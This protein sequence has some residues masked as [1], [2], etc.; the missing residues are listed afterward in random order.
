M[1]AILGDYAPVTS[2]GSISISL[3]VLAT[4]HVGAGTYGLCHLSTRTSRDGGLIHDS[5]NNRYDVASA[6][7]AARVNARGGRGLSA[8]RTALLTKPNPDAAAH[9]GAAQGAHVR[10]AAGPTSQNN[11][12]G[13]TFDKKKPSSGY[14]LAYQDAVGSCANKP[15]TRA[16][17]PSIRMGMPFNRTPRGG[18]IDHRPVRLATTRD[19]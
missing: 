15:S 4:L 9:T 19:T 1:P 3:L 18:R 8:A 2:P 12:S 13:H 5:G 7:A 17:T 10:G 11:W 6:V 16:R 14:Y